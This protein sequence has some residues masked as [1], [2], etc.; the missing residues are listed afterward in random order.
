VLLLDRAN[1]QG[2]AAIAREAAHVAGEAAALTPRNSVAYAATLELQGVVEQLLADLEERPADDAVALLEQALAAT[3]SSS[4]EFR[5]RLVHL[6][7]ALAARADRDSD[8]Q[9]ATRALAAADQA[10]TL[11]EDHNVLASVP[12]RHRATA[13]RVRFRLLDDDA[14][15]VAAT[16]AFRGALDASASTRLRYAL[17]TAREW[18]RWAAQRDAWSEAVEAG[19]R[20]LALATELLRRQVGRVD[21]EGALDQAPIIAGDQAYALARMGRLRQAVMVLEHGRALLLAESLRRNLADL[22]TLRAEGQTAL[23]DRF[24]AAVARIRALESAEPRSETAVSL[25]RPWATFPPEPERDRSA[26]LAAATEELE[27]AITAVRNVPGREHFLADSQFPAPRSP[28][29]YLTGTTN[30]G[31]GLVVHPDGQIEALWLPQLEAYEVRAQVRTWLTA[32]DA[33]AEDR[34]GW[35]HTFDATLRWAWTAAMG[36]VVECLRGQERATLVPGGLLGL[37]PLHAAWISDSATSSGRRHALDQLL[38][39]YTPSAAILE[40]VSFGVPVHAPRSLLAVADPQPVSAAPLPWATREVSVAARCFSSV[41]LLAG[42]KATRTAVVEH[43]DGHDVLHFACHGLADPADPQRSA[44]ILAHDE[45]L[46]L[47]DLASMRLMAGP[48]ERPRLA[49]LSACESGMPTGAL[50]DEVVGLPTGFLSAGVHGVVSSLVTVPDAATGLL[51]TRF[52]ETWTG[53]REPMHALRD[54]QRWLRD[55]TNEQIHALFGQALAGTPPVSP[56]ARRLWATAR[57]FA[58]PVNWAAFTYVGT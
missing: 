32:Y 12:L 16:E 35:A 27:R 7:G 48:G 29:V 26:E 42:P 44:L 3:D 1:L 46:T 4:P 17:A 50:P 39:S 31:L 10:L 36:H 19:E 20:G 18:Q 15:R 55:A 37:L 24:E 43:L 5:V 28:L 53:G 47:A 22:T 33:R 9:E 21:R 51:M 58:H 25:E 52:Y 54:A 49:V 41:K 45:P 11:V 6:A 23:A 57:P 30:G 14:D 56:A 34:S 13:L 2:N 38:L 40:E 8:A